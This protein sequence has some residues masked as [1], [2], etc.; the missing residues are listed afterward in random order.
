MS[1]QL[2]SIVVLSALF[3]GATVAVAQQRRS[4]GDPSLGERL[5]SFRGSGLNE[6]VMMLV[7]I[8]RRLP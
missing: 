7:V 5:E 8:A 6:V 1:R 3:V 4:S 2:A